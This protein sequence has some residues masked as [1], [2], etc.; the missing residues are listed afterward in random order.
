MDLIGEIDS[1]FVEEKYRNYGLG[2]R[3]MKR[4]LEWLNSNH[5][6]TKIIMVAEG[7]ENVLEFYKKYGFYK[8]RII[9]EQ[10]NW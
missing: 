5:V 8:R 1:I 3:L 4:A 6:K 10:I 7:N 9:L 2:D